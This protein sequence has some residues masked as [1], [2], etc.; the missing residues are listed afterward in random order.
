M[1]FQ[2]SLF[3]AVNVE[4]GDGYITAVSLYS[5]ELEVGEIALHWRPTK[6]MEY[7]S[8][9]MKW[10]SNAYTIIVRGARL[11]YEDRPKDIQITANPQ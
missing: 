4:I 9:L 5:R 2:N 7:G 10:T 8:S 11:R 1:S 6:P 3:E